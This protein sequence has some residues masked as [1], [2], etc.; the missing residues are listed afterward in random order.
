MLQNSWQFQ[1]HQQQAAYCSLQFLCCSV[2][3]VCAAGPATVAAAATRG[4]QSPA[5]SGD[6]LLLMAV[7]ADGRVWQ[8]EAALPRYPSRSALGLSGGDKQP[9]RPAGRGQAS[10]V[11][12]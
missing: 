12:L 9:S 1:Q 3:V 4:G 7:T 10:V 6:C 5:L 8:W 2:G 11:L